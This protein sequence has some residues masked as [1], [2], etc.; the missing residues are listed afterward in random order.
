MTVALVLLGIAV[1]LLILRVELV[2]ILMFV[3]AIIHLVWGGGALEYLLQDMWA[4]M[5]RELILSVPLFILVGAVMGRGSIA[6]R[7]VAVMTALTRS[8]P[9]GLAVATIL[10]CAVFSAIS[11]SSIVTMLAVGSVLYPALIA[12]GYSR[13]FAL[14]ALCAGGTL[15]IVIPPSLPMILYG[16]VTETNIADLFLAGIGPGLL[17]TGVFSIYAIAVNWK[18]PRQP[19]SLTDLGKAAF[20]GIPA[21]L[22]PVILL[23]GIYSGYY[24]PTESAAIALLYAL[25]VEVVFYRELKSRDYVQICV[26]SAKLVGALF[27]LIAVAVSLNLVIAEH[28]IPDQIIAFMTDHVH[29]QTMFLLLT[30]VLLLAIG[31]FM[32]TASSIAIAAPLLKPL[33]EAYGVGST[34]L[35]VIIVLNLEI[36]ILTPPL[37]LNLIVAMTAFKE[38]FGFVC[39][40]AI[41]FVLLMIL[42]LL[43]VT[44]QPWIAMALVNAR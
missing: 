35:G 36:G 27:P 13:S 11:G 10:S 41:P 26:E 23:G 4:T 31:C 16:V 30:N 34:H 20:R 29:N 12:N 33:A 19:F 40:A 9:G 5:D 3:A 1:L 7:L 39:R 38:N 37:G 22:M 43:L 24:S 32:D 25:V 42:C 14:G 15:G 44:F 6:A 21:L 2:L 28:R 18:V 17:L 8:I